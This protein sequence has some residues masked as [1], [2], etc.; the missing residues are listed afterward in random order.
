MLICAFVLVSCCPCSVA[1][2]SSTTDHPVSVIEADIYVTKFKT[3]MRLKCFAEDLNLL[4]GVEA[5]E[6]GFYDTDEL[7]ETTKD[8]AKYLAEKIQ[9]LDV[10]GS[11]LKAKVVEVVDFEL[12]NGRVR[13]GDL[14]QHT[15]EI[16][17]EYN[18]DD[19]PEFLTLK[20]QIVSEDVGLPSE[21][22]ILLKQEGSPEPFFHMMKPDK[23]ETFQ[24]DWSKNAPE[25]DASDEEW[26]S[27]F[28][29]QRE[30]NLGITSYSSVYAFI[31]VTNYQ[32]RVEVLIPVATLTTFFEIERAEESFLSIPEQDVV[33]KKIERLFSIG[34]R[35]EIDNIEVAPVFDRVDFYGLDLRDFAVQAERRKVSMA[36]GRAGIIMSYSTKGIPRDVKVTWEKFNESVKTVDAVVFAFEDL[37][38]AEFSMFLDD[39]TYHWTSDD[40]KPPTPITEVTTDAKIYR[41]PMLKLP[42]VSL[43]LAALA[44]P[45]IVCIPFTKKYLGVGLVA[46]ALVAGCFLFADA[47][48]FP[49]AHP[50]EVA[51]VIEEEKAADIFEQLHKNMFRAFDYHSESQIYDALARSVEGDLLQQLYL[52]ISDSLRVA[53]QGGA[54]S[55]IE[56]V[57]FVDGQVIAVP[58]AA[59]S[60]STL[61]DNEQHPSFNFRCQWE[62]LGTVEHWGHIH[63]RN[64]KYDAEFQVQL[65]EDGWKITKMDLKDFDHDAIKTRVRK[66]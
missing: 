42:V 25:T 6:D 16:V 49:I 22:K 35:V 56:R 7:R 24:M 19:P 31:Y 36:S 23:P 37:K 29:E 15:I 28:E 38:K 26:E 66:L 43:I 30:K 39:N 13:E 50:F 41:T 10:S 65:L 60:D 2:A 4:H 3:T 52:E 44:L 11:M 54:I 21:L 63:E 1:N 5:L 59:T 33:A 17:L 57:D 40:R 20:Q 53:E 14:M 46:S 34:N 32:V 55:S 48:P 58:E 9:V 47:M 62:L 18:H 12:P 61:A 27:W 45:L 51:K 8:H 64:N